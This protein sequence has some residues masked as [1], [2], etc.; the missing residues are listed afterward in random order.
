MISSLVKIHRSINNSKQDTNTNSHNHDIKT[1]IP[2]Y[3]EIFDKNIILISINTT[4]I[5]RT[6][7]KNQQS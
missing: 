7:N 5:N 2:S 4:I 3:I 1:I 6:N